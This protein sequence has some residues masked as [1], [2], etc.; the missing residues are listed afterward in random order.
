MQLLGFKT[1]GV[2]RYLSA[3]QQ[4][5]INEGLTFSQFITIEDQL[6]TIV[7][8]DYPLIFDQEIPSTYDVLG[9]KY[10]NG[11]SSVLYGKEIDSSYDTLSGKIST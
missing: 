8:V 9:G 3:D 1:T 6:D 5:I 2:L 10:A 4:T 11:S 7:N